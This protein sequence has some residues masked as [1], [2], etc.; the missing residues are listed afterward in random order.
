MKME[1]EGKEP[2]MV[3]FGV[4]IVTTCIVLI[5]MH[6]GQSHVR[7]LP[8]ATIHVEAPHVTPK[9]IAILPAGA[10]QITNEVPPA[11]IHEVV[12]E[13]VRVP[14]VEI[15][16]RIPN[17][18][19]PEI[20]ISLPKGGPYAPKVIPM[21]IPVSVKEEPAEEQPPE[22]KAPKKKHPEGRL[23]PPPDEPGVR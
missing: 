13:I 2:L 1:M 10:I 16:N 9:V 8:P 23:L 3:L 17:A 5:S 12:R 7:V 15:T 21:P 20:H 4:P 14:N 11:Q 22:K 18:P 6:L 19:A